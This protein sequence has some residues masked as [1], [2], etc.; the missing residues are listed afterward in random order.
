MAEWPLF[1]CMPCRCQLA[2]SRAFVAHCRRHHQRRQRRL[3]ITRKQAT[4]L[5]G[6]HHHQAQH[7]HKQ[8]S[9]EALTGRQ[10][11][12][13]IFLVA[14]R[15]KRLFVAKHASSGLVPVTRPFEQHNE[16]NT[17]NNEEYD[18]HDH[19]HD[20]DDG[21]GDNNDYNYDEEGDNDDR[22]EKDLLTASDADEENDEEDEAQEEDEADDDDDDDN[23]D[24]EANSSGDFG[25]DERE[26][27]TTTSRA[28][29][30][31]LF[32]DVRHCG[33]GSIEHVFA[34][35]KHIYE[36][37]STPGLITSTQ[38]INTT[39]IAAAQ[40]PAPVTTVTSTQPVPATTTTTATS[41]ST[42][43]SRN[44]CKK[45]K[46]PKCNWHYKYRET[47]DIHMREKHASELSYSESQQRCVYCMENSQHPRLGRGEQYKCGYKPYRCDI[48]DYST[49]TKGNLSIHMQSEKH[50]N[51]VKESNN[52]SSQQ[53]QQ[54]P[55]DDQQQQEQSNENRSAE[56]ASDSLTCPL[57][58]QE[59]ASDQVRD[60]IIL[61]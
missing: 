42:Q 15:I 22:Y 52:G 39:P 59:C 12:V 24:Y 6:E 33:G 47:L 2:T 43:H 35:L 30:A 26:A 27:T 61:F 25:E 3:H 5:L 23:D 16:N 14:S 49:T 40:A 19:D 56:K 18:D 29:Y 8:R 48:C 31:L 58:H 11:Q 53:Q 9:Y 36:E 4:F 44:A 13:A 28:P 60:K 32:V 34:R 51:N 54:Q 10:H 17:N 21:H 37:S 46:C 38:T 1:F 57:C 20:N 7:K 50:L 55:R 41:T 45:L